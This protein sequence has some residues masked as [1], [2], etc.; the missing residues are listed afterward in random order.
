VAGKTS[1][2]D[3]EVERKGHDEGGAACDIRGCW[4]LCQWF[5]RKKGDGKEPERNPGGSSISV[6][7][8]RLRTKKKITESN[9]RF[10]RKV[11]RGG[12]HGE[13]G[14]C[15]LRGCIGQPIGGETHSDLSQFH[16]EGGLQRGG[17]NELAG[18]FQES[19]GK[20]ILVTWVRGTGPDSPKR[21]KE[22]QKKKGIKREKGLAGGMM[23]SAFGGWKQY[24]L[25]LNIA[26]DG[27]GQIR[28]L[29]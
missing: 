6:E 20:N 7:H 19:N 15:S 16:H 23:A 28:K 18:Q 8:L 10:T 26:R 27:L 22:K 24:E 9:F 13:Q 21:N 1:G 2:N 4:T 17:R 14:N 29:L 25:F 3:Q 12:N 5:G 11:E